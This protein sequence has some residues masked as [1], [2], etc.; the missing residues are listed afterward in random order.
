MTGPRRV[1]VVTGAGGAIGTA[2]CRR[3]AADGLAVV[4]ADVDGAAAQA[5]ATAVDDAG[6]DATAVPCDVR[7]RDDIRAA[8]E[9][10]VAQFGRLDVMCNNAGISLFK[11]LLEVTEDDWHRI[12][13]V[14]ALGV[15][16]GTQEAARRMIE[17]GDG[18]RIVNTSS[19][20]GKTGWPLVA[21]YSASKFAVV[22]LTQSSARALG[23]HGIL[24]NAVCPGVVDSSMMRQVDEQSVALGAPTSTESV[25]AHSILR[26]VGEP[27][28][29][30]ALVAFLA[31]DDSRLI[32][33]QSIQV[34][35]GIVL[36]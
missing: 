8:V 18:G 27:E 34:D 21:A 2:I 26:R 9:L 3:L 6:G 36:Q 25:E 29:V 23:V 22:A 5:T 32:T 11:P 16:L 7:V 10:A 12:N 35:G 17:Q 1:A 4:A 19:V 28:E 15:L 24:V 20:A 14:N 31:G 30:A 33:G 13:D